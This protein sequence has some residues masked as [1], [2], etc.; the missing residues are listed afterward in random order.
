MGGEPEPDSERGQDALEFALITPL[1]MLLLLGILEFSLMMFSYNSVSNAAREGARYGTVH[2]TDTTGIANAARPSL[3]G[4]PSATVASTYF[5][6]TKTVCVQ[7]QYDYQLISAPMLRTL[8]GS[9]KI[10]LAAAATM[11]TEN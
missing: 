5:A 11:N 7:V 3:T 9:G 1:L 4:L 2:P 8:G 6:L 10:H